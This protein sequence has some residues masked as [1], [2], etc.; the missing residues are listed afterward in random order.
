LSPFPITVLTFNSGSSSLKF[1]LYRVGAG[2]PVA[3][4]SGEIEALGDGRC[5]LRASD[6]GGASLIDETSAMADP[7]AGVSRLGAMFKRAQ[8]P[9]PAAIGHRVVHGGPTLRRHCLIDDAVLVTLAAAVAFAPLHLPPALA[10][11]R[12]ARQH[13]PGLPQAAC[14]DTAFHADMPETARTLPLPAALRAQGIQRYG[15]HGLSCESIMRQLGRDV[16]GRVVIAHLGNGASITA[17]KARRS[18]DTSMGLT[19]SGGVIMGTRTGDIDPGV[20]L[21]LLREQGLDAAALEDIVDRRSGLLGLSGVSSDLR[22]LHA[23]GEPGAR[24]ALE[25]F[26]I[27]VAKQIAG[28]IVA[29]GGIDRLVFTGG[30]GENDAATR[31]GIVERLACLGRIAVQI[32][33]S[34]EDDE[35]ARHTAVLAHPMRGH[36]VSR[37]SDDP[38]R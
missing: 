9:A 35:I 7:A 6:A 25:M 26:E 32:L 31:D 4:V 23:S 13:F 20:L 1:G 3:V 33:P 17:V 24:L 2:D 12:Y 19:P 8:A 21:Y 18:I 36:P 29:L 22:R 37:S 30:I 16:P 14:F 11:M 28:M 38:I 5:R 10:V 27:S 34:R 15:F